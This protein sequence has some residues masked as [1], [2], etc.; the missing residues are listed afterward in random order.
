LFV[1]VGGVSSDLVLSYLSVMELSETFEAQSF[2]LPTFS[3]MTVTD[4]ED[5]IEE[6]EEFASFIR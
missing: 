2:I 6:N 3:E 4:L 5:M 1:V